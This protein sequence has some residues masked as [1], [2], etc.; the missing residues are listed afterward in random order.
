MYKSIH[1]LILMSNTSMIVAKT[2]VVVAMVPDF[3]SDTDAELTSI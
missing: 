1:V 2:N 3:K